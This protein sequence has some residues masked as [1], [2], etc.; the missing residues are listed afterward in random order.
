MI[1]DF[2]YIENTLPNT[3]V[4]MMGHPHLFY[5]P[6]ANDRS[7]FAGCMAAPVAIRRDRS[8]YAAIMAASA[9][10]YLAELPTIREL[11]ARTEREGVRGHDALFERLRT[12]V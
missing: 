12:Q 4:G 5:M 9:A 10:P 8:F 2:N 7:I 6:P 1:H 11:A 3:Q